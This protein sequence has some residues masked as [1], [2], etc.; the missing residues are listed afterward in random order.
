M[1]KK[2]V[3]ELL[4]AAKKKRDK[5]QKKA[6]K[7]VKDVIPPIL[8]PA[9]RAAPSI[10]S[11]LTEIQNAVIDRI[12]DRAFRDFEGLEIGGTDPVR[13]P[14]RRERSPEQKE[15]VAAAQA[16]ATARIKK[17]LA[18]GEIAYDEGGE[19]TDKIV[20]NMFEEGEFA[21][22]PNFNTIFPQP[23]QDNPLMN[24]REALRRYTQ[25]GRF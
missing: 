17:A 4:A 5:I 6:I 16:S 1:A 3:A 8:G 15:R 25:G 22:S 2:T 12:A 10:A 18:R 14:W 7:Q 11:G 21:S 20:E 24:P 13:E 9:G 19:L 23:Q